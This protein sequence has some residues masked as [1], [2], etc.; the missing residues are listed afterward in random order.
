MNG[1]LF[2]AAIF[3][4]I[5]FALPIS[6]VKWKKE[7]YW[8]I[9]AELVVILTSLLVFYSIGHSDGQMHLLFRF[10]NDLEVGFRIDGL[11]SVFAALVS[12][13]WPLATLYAFE[14][15]KELDNRENFFMFYVM[16]F[17]VTLGIAFSG[18]YL[19]Q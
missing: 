13:L 16:T 19:T 3:L 4:P 8:M 15:M 11:A 5:L 14:Y 9:Y 7:G 12:F 1:A 2:V 18:N 6:L 10:A 17:G